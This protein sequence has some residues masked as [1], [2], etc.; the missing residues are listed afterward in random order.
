MG[1]KRPASAETKISAGG[2]GEGDGDA[3]AVTIEYL[4]T[5]YRLYTQSVYTVL[6]FYIL[7]FTLALNAY[8]HVFDADNSVGELAGLTIGGFGLV[9]A[10]LFYLLD[11]RSND[12]L[13]AV[14]AS[15]EAWERDNLA[16]EYHF[17]AKPVKTDRPW[18]RH[19][20]LI[21]ALYILS[22]VAFLAMVLRAYA[23]M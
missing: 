1:R 18:Q 14:E 4:M 19:R 8:V 22:L 13:L 12:L 11:Q 17:L 15:I 5:H 6:S 2:R 20:V 9:L 16:A 7:A 10:G 21:P 3:A 23:S